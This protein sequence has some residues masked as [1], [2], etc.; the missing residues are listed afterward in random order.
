MRRSLRTLAVALAAVAGV[1]AITSQAALANDRGNS[2]SSGYGSS[3]YGSSTHGYHQPSTLPAASVTRV[4]VNKHDDVTKNN[5]V[6]NGNTISLGLDPAGNLILVPI[7]ALDNNSTLNHV[8]ALNGSGLVGQSFNN[9]LDSN[10]IA[11][12]GGIANNDLNHSGVA[13]H[14]L[15]DHGLTAK[16]LTSKVDNNQ[17]APDNQV[18]AGPVDG[19]VGGITSGGVAGGLLGN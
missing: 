7:S 2:S 3:G 12:Q 14:V 4:V 1:A 6:L 9:L 5:G 10:D 8:G 19:L 16:T 13:T 15:Q 11:G 18:N 17:A